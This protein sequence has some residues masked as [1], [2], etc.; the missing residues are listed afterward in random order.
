MCAVIFKR[1]NN[2]LKDHKSTKRSQNYY[3]DSGLCSIGRVLMNFGNVTG[4][5]KR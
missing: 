4:N 2:I 3:Q 5:I 1:Q